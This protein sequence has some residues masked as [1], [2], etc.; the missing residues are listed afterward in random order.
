MLAILIGLGWGTAT[1]QPARGVVIGTGIGALIAVL[2]WL[3]D[4]KT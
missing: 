4:R 3:L 1:G 2:L